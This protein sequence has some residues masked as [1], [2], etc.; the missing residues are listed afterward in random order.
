MTDKILTFGAKYVS[1]LVVQVTILET[2]VLWGQ[3]LAENGLCL[4][5]LEDTVQ[6]ADLD[7]LLNE[8]LAI[9]TLFLR[10]R[11]L[12]PGLNAELAKYGRTLTT[13]LGTSDTAETDATE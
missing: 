2:L 9:W 5:D 6:P 8:T 11:P 13:H 1:Q 3:S 12:V 4:V 7:K 10:F